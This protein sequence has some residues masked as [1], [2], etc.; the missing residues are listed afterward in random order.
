MH[1]GYVREVLRPHTS[2]K[3]KKKKKKKKKKITWYELSFHHLRKSYSKQSSF[4]LTIQPAWRCVVASLRAVQ[5][6]QSKLICYTDIAYS[7]KL[8]LQRWSKLVNLSLKDSHCH[9]FC[10]F[11]TSLPNWYPALLNQRTRF[12][13]WMR[14]QLSKNSGQWTL[15][16][17]R[18]HLAKT[19]LRAYADSK[20][21]DHPAHPHRLI[22]A[23]N[24]R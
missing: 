13:K 9:T 19:C 7:Y 2:H 21:P 24:V 1:Y 8:M 12:T 23:F 20:G 22:R 17:F 3:I 11:Q 6:N 5:E 10:W 16:Q 14:V 4:A 18:P 15:L